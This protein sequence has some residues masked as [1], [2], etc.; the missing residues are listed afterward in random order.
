MIID[1]SEG[2]FTDKLLVPSCFGQDAWRW[3]ING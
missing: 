2:E 1:E 3:K